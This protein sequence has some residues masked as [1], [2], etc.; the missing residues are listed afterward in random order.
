MEFFYKPTFIKDFNSFEKLLQ[1]EIIQKI[2][3]FKDTKNHK[4]LRVHKL[5]GRLKG[6][7]G[8]YVN[9]KYRI[10]FEYKN[11]KQVHFLTVG[12]HDIYI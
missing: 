7:Y 1:E 8:F 6:L 9:Y 12:D 11:K 10:I 5:H 3:L 4:Q 2:E